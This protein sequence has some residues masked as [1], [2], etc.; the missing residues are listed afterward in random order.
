MYTCTGEHIYMNSCIHAHTKRVKQLEDSHDEEGGK[1]Q[2]QMD[3]VCRTPRI[4]K[5][6]WK[7]KLPHTMKYPLDSSSMAGAWPKKCFC[8]L[9]SLS[10]CYTLQEKLLT[11]PLPAAVRCQQLSKGRVH[12]HLLCPMLGLGLGRVCVDHVHAVTI[13]VSSYVFIYQKHWGVL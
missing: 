8:G 3:E 1:I 6:F 7:L 4:K 11:C 2:E 9:K 13:A 5:K 10:R 12:A